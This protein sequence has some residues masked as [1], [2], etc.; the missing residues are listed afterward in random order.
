MN[1]LSKLVIVKTIVAGMFLN[2]RTGALSSETTC[3]ATI[4]GADVGT[5]VGAPVG[6]CE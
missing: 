6:V 1:A 2:M 4:V 3:G 5:C